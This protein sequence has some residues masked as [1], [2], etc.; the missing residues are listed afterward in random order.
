MAKKN[1]VQIRS[2]LAA[3]L[4]V[5]L[6]N[7]GQRRNDNKIDSDDLFGASG[8]ALEDTIHFN[9]NFP[10]ISRLEVLLKEKE[11]LGLYVSGN[12]L[13]DYERLAH[14]MKQVSYRDDVYLVVLNKIRK[15]FTKKGLMMFALELSTPDGDYEGIIFP[16]KAM[17]F[18]TILKERD[19]FM[20]KGKL[21]QKEE[22]TVTKV[23]EEGELQEF[24]EIPKILIDNIIPFE[25][26]LPALLKD[27]EATLAS[28]TFQRNTDG[29]DWQLL[30]DQPH[31]LF[32]GGGKSLPN[33]SQPTESPH[34]VEEIKE[35][36]VRLTRSLGL[37]RIKE[38]KSKLQKNSLPGYIPVVIEIEAG[39]GEFKR[40]KGTYYL[41]QQTIQS[42]TS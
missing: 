21:D 16:K 32:S 24:D 15:I 4:D 8:A 6:D 33:S 19:I 26:G 12:P 41:D 2:F 7:L 3:N 22:K 42:L 28:M 30:K 29:L 14:W 23:S 35:H 18:S 9:T 11:A 37:E 20:V 39:N 1:Y 34:S 31:V 36:I 38:I 17:E 40:A 27:D 13:Q 25:Q 5:L 10:G